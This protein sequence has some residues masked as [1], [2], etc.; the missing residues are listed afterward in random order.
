MVR[1][2]QRALL[3]LLLGA[4]LGLGFNAFSPRRIPYRTP[5]KVSLLTNDVVSLPVAQQLWTGGAAFFLDA[6]APADYAAGHIPY[7][8]N[9]PVEAFAA[10]WPQVEPLLT[11]EMELVVYCD[12]AE[13]ELS[14]RL[15]Q[16][17]RQLGYSKVRVLVN[18]MTVWRKAGLPVT[19]G[20]T[21]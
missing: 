12:G 4:A 10:H 14:H 9:L 19:M 20:E 3:I 8:F 18:G 16:Q 5:P 2:F 1:T 11:R 17:L 15:Q 21:P 13:C 7:A 6:R